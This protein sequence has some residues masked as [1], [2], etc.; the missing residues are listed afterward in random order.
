MI[1][2]LRAKRVTIVLFLSITAVSLFALTLKITGPQLSWDGQDYAQLARQ[3]ARGEGHTSKVLISSFAQDVRDE[4]AWPSTFR[5][6]FPVFLTSLSFKLFGVSDT[7]AVLWSGL[8]YV[9][10]VGLIFLGFEPI[11]GA[12]VA[13]IS[14]LIFALS[15]CGLIYARSGLTEPSAMFFLLLGFALAVNKDSGPWALLAGASLSLCA[16]NRPIAYLWAVVVLG[17]PFFR[18]SSRD[19]RLTRLCLGGVGF[20]LPLL[21]IKFGLHWNGGGHDLF[22]VNLA[23]RIGDESLAAQSPV[24]FVFRHPFEML[25]K[26][27]HEAMRVCMYLFQFGNIP[28]FSALSIFALFLPA[29]PA[30]RDARNMTI[31]LVG[32]TAAALTFL[33]EGDAFVGPLRYF[34]VFTPLLLPWG[35]S[36]FR[37]FLRSP[38]GAPNY[39]TWCLF[40][41]YLLGTGSQAI[42]DPFARLHSSDQA[43]YRELSEI[44]PEK[45]VVA[46]ATVNVP[47]IAW[48]GD[49]KAVFLEGDIENSLSVLRQNGIAVEWYLGKESDQIPIGFRKTRQWPGGFVL[50]RRSD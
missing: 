35:V 21:F 6:P 32:L 48:Y 7:T 27:M 23:S 14:A 49:R 47:S 42:R 38:T 15:G 39:V 24:R 30:Q 8:F 45:Q 37:S 43:V 28:L 18:N 29:Q 44:V 5:P 13:F 3:L 16:L 31:A 36:A 17:Y 19:R 50:F 34:D 10:T 20:V 4:Q 46:A 11:H 1:I 22:A 41:L 26:V 40:A 33:T 12:E 25:A 9:G 2:E